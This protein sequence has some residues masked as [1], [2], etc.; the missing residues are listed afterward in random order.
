MSAAAP[1]SAAAA[2]RVRVGWLVLGALAHLAVLLAFLAP[3]MVDASGV[4]GLP[5]R[6]LFDHLWLHDWLSGV[7]LGGG[8]WLHTQAI[9]WPEG[10]RLLHP[11]LVGWGLFLP[12]S[13]LLGMVGG[14]DAMVVGQLWLCALA[15]WL[16][17]ARVSGSALAGWFSGLAFGASGLL[18]GQSLTGETETLAAWPLVLGVWALERTAS[19]ERWAD[20]VLAGALGALTAV[21]SWYYGAFFAV[22]LLAWAALRCRHRVAL[23]SLG[24]FAL[25]V[26]GPAWVYRGMLGQPDNLFQGPSLAT[27]VADHPATLAGMVGDPAG[28]FGFM[29]GV[30]AAAGHPRVQYLGTVVVLLALTGLWVRRRR[31]WWL[32]VGLVGLLLSLGPVLHLAGE[33]LRLAGRPL[34]GPLAALAWLPLVGLMRIPHRWLLLAVLSLSVLAARGL[35]VLA[36]DELASPAARRSRPRLPVL[37][38]LCSAL[39]VVDLALF[40]D[41]TGLGMAGRGL[42][43]VQDLDQPPPIHR[44]LPGRGAVLDLPPRILGDD[45]R[46]HYLVWQRHHGRPVPYSLLMTGLSPSLATE[47]LVAAVAA[48]DR[49][50]PISLRPE[51][52]AQFRREDLAHL[53]QER[54]FGDAGERGLADAA[55]RLAGMGFDTVVLHADLLEPEDATLVGEM[56]ERY[57]GPPAREHQGSRAWALGVTP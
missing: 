25:L 10:G 31:W 50:D 48:M 40:A 19:R 36:G 43:S 33:P 52:A 32:G 44:D 29:P 21:G 37:V 28:W 9:A 53:A 8:D 2:P 7:A 35:R 20:A 3:A 27:Y 5:T 47:P 15:A 6:D 51:D 13:R 17:G 16:L 55:S 39:L 56:L 57:L 4:V 41:V 12:L 14:Y 18:I 38:G 42:P 49:R 34:P 46:G 45:A 11:D 23:A 26:A 1:P 22:Y 30:L 54:R 24:A